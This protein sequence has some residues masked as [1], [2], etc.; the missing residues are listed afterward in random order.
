MSARDELDDNAWAEIQHHLVEMARSMERS[1]ERRPKAKEF[2]QILSEALSGISTEIFEDV[3][4]AAI[5]EIKATFHK[6]PRKII[7]GTIAAVPVGEVW[8]PVIYITRNRFGEAFGIFNEKLEKPVLPPS[9]APEPIHF[10]FYTTMHEIRAGTWPI[11]GERSDLLR[12]FPSQPET[13]FAKHWPGTKDNPRIGPYG[14][15]ESPMTRC[16]IFHKMRPSEWVYWTIAI[17][18]R[19]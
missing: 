16:A 7:P 15:A 8:V 13:Y 2:V 14:A 9:W 12:H 10:P 1:T 18:L 4:P 3:S 6:I 17:N 11:L 19:Y 5:K